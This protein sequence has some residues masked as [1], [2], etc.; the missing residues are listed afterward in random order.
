MID[1]TTNFRCPVCDEMLFEK[2]N[3][4]N[5]YY[6]RK[7]YKC[8]YILTFTQQKPIRY[9]E[10]SAKDRNGL[11]FDCDYCEQEP[12]KSKTCRL[13]EKH[14]ILCDVKFAY[15]VKSFYCNKRVENE[16]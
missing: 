7:C 12:G 6:S 3:T 16:D 9:S 13:G 4:S 8:G 1:M 15:G 2:V 11:C 5:G 14:W 10:V